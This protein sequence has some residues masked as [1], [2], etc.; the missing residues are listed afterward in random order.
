MNDVQLASFRT[1]ADAMLGSNRIWNWHSDADRWAPAQMLM[2]VTEKQAR[3]WQR[4]YGG[5]ITCDFKIEA[6]P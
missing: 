1:I 3:D 4:K 2:S 5:T 6:K